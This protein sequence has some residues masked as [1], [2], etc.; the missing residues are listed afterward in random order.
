MTTLKDMRTY[1]MRVNAWALNHSREDYEVFI[2]RQ[3]ETLHDD[4]QALALRLEFADL[5]GDSIK[6]S[7]D[8]GIIWR[9]VA[10]VDCF[11]E[12]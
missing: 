5:D 1:D 6:V 12:P 2:R 3:I 8:V 10:F 9:A 11:I 7:D 4:L